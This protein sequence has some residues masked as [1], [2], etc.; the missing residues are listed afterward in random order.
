VSVDPGELKQIGLITHRTQIGEAVATVGE[1]HR[2]IA[3]HASRVVALAQPRQL[4]SKRGGQA[5]AISDC[6]QQ[7]ATGMRDQTGSVRRDFYN[8]L[9]AA[10]HGPAVINPDDT[11]LTTTATATAAGEP[12]PREE[13]LV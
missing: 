13:G 2:Q 1:H 5:N 7:A 4:V 10:G 12:E 6:G 9:H 8:A 11:H 3:D